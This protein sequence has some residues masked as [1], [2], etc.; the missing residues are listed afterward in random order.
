MRIVFET[1]DTRNR[2]PFA[3]SYP[4]LTK[5]DVP[6]VNVGDQICYM[7][8]GTMFKGGLRRAAAKVC[9]AALRRI[10]A[11]YKMDVDTAR[12]SMIGGIKGSG[13]AAH[14]NPKILEEVRRKN[15]IMELHGSGAPAMTAGCGMFGLMYSTTA[16][17]GELNNYGKINFDRSTRLPVIRRSLLNDPSVNVMTD[18]ANPEKMMGDADMN[19]RR[20]RAAKDIDNWRKLEGKLGRG[21]TLQKREINLLANAKTALAVEFG[22]ECTTLADAEIAYAAFTKGMT[23]SGTADVSEANLHSFV[24]V[25]PDTVWKHMFE[26]HHPSETAIG[27]FMESWHHKTCFSPFIGGNVARGC[28][29]YMEGTYTVRRQE[30][31]EWITDCLITVR[32]DYGV[33]VASV[34]NSGPSVV[35]QAWDKWKD[36][37]ISQFVF[38]YKAI[39]SI[40]NESPE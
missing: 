22:Q 14:P 13:S 40:L 20:S 28:G 29:G 24:F 30:G 6:Y 23:E 39:Q 2:M 18:I 5:G 38:D 3:T 7:I 37:D 21:E 31:T 17:K 4:D 36:V 33:S 1:N 8:T 25:P 9:I 16:V 15:P 10:D 34:S 19:R 12:L 32:P 35:Q 27:L 11:E 26:L